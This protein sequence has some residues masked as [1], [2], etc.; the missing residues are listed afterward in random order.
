MK[1]LLL[2]T[3]CL[4]AFWNAYAVNL[5][6]SGNGEVLLFPYYTVN[7]G[8]N[9]SI[10][11]VNTTDS[12]KALRVRFREAANN[13][14]VFTFNLYLGPH[15]T[16]AG[17]VNKGSSVQG[18]MTE[19]KTIDKSCTLPFIGTNGVLFNTDK[20][21]NSFAD[22]YGTDVNRMHEG[23]IE[24]I[25]MGELNGVSASATLINQS[26]PN[27]NC[28]VLL[29]AWDINSA[30]SYWLSNPNSDM[31]PPQ[32]GITGSVVLIDT[33]NG[34]EIKQQATILEDFSR[35]ILHFNV[36][37]DSPSLADASAISKITDVNDNTQ[38]FNWA[39]GIEAVSSVL[40]K[41]S[42]AN[43]NEIDTDVTT[44][45]IATLPTRQ[46]HTDPVYAVSG[47]PLKPFEINAV[48]GISCEQFNDNGVYDRE[49]QQP[50]S[51]LYTA[52][53]FCYGVNNLS[54]LKDVNNPVLPTG[55]FASQF[56]ASINDAG[57]LIGNHLV[58]PF[59]LGWVNI[60][61]NQ[62][63]E[64]ITN[65]KSIAGLPIIGFST[66]AHL[67]NNVIANTLTNYAQASNQ[68][69]VITINPITIKSTSQRDGQK[70]I[71]GQTQPMSIAEDNIGQVLIYPYY[72]VKNNLNT[73]V[74]VVNTT[75][76]V[77]ALKIHFKEGKN[78]RLALGFN[79]YVG[80]YDVWTATLVAT[81]ATA[82]FSPNHVGEPT[83]MLLTSDTSC[84]LPINL[85]GYEFLPYAFDGAFVD[86]LGIN[87]ERTQEGVI[88][89]YEMGTVI[90]E[91]ANAATHIN[92]IP[93]DCQ[94]LSN[95]WAPNGK[96]DI[97]PTQNMLPPD[98]SGGLFGTASIVNADA[99]I[100]MHY[101]ATGIVNFNS[102][103][104]HVPIGDFLP[105]LRTGN[106]Y[107][108]VIK[109]QN[110]PIQTTWNSTIDAV[111]ALF[112]QTQSI[113]DFD[114]L[115]NGQSEWVNIYPTKQFYVDSL[116]SA[117]TPPVM[118]FTQELVADFG[119]CEDHRFSAF[120]TEQKI[121]TP[122]MV[123]PVP[124]PLP[125]NYSEMP[126]N[127]W[128]VNVSDVNSGLDNNTVFSTILNINDFNNDPLHTSINDLPFDSGWMR[129][130]YVNGIANQGKI[131][132]VGSDG[133][134][135]EIYGKP[136][137]GFVIQKS[138]QDTDGMG[139]MAH[140][141]T[142]KMN[143]GIVHIKVFDEL[144]ANGFE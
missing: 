53:N 81:Q 46:Y 114:I 117:S 131:I 43:T 120:D 137:L 77:K 112:M 32:G 30:N 50:A 33:F 143:Q 59:S 99:G 123:V 51:S 29:D 55:V 86:Q 115:N 62:S 78:A 89:I 92:G 109:T 90:G 16:W 23:F 24:V 111:S 85:S 8:F 49:Q 19:L 37:N 70:H 68:K 124:D 69:S 58:T 104:M 39:T 128:S 96:W 110:G 106:N 60:S 129:N 45:W 80:P 126:E 2:L 141:T 54:I 36:D 6:T 12:A 136:V 21:I 20:F 139:T 118:P 4:M 11:L 83:V 95:N 52:S 18:F 22:A 41:S 76:Q 15:D 113:N 107:D 93:A 130:D 138:I 57:N 56:P 140:F 127:C 38:A 94:L 13:R 74:T 48:N 133:S 9:T 87:L 66:Q 7:A 101:M 40:M 27:A 28:S 142:L 125:P 71:Q 14:E 98:G 17:N 91:D 72:T 61:M 84:T 75:D 47:I 105:N 97:D 103:L 67:N 31:T 35:D 82:L 135:H 116:F 100:E 34:I 144:F 65:N 88:E 63:L 5:S 1:K 44:D 119:A 73:L 108:T 26:Q 132:G 3:L 42:M 121:N 10:K 122:P 25:E 64:N 79:V 102:S 134:P